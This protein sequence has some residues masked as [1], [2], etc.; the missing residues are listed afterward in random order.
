ML[1]MVNANLSPR[2][3][4]SP[5]SFRTVDIITSTKFNPPICHGGRELLHVGGER[6]AASEVR[7]RSLEFIGAVQ[8]NLVNRGKS[9]LQIPIETVELRPSVSIF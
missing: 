7:S 8:F 3:R 2:Q 9:T 1:L 6:A 5:S 4:V